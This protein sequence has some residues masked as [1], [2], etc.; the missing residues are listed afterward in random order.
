M[1]KKL[2]E[3][4][5]LANNIWHEDKFNFT[6]VCDVSKGWHLTITHECKDKTGFHPEIGVYSSYISDENI[7]EKI[8]EIRVNFIQKIQKVAEFRK[9]N[10]EKLYENLKKANEEF[11][12]KLYLL[13]KLKSI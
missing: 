12:Q 3:I 10:C 7:D 11:T 2:Q 6:M 1:L 8:A 13:E 4:H 9:E 5:K